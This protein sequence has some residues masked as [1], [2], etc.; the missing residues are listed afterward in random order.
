[1]A[2]KSHPDYARQRLFIEVN[3]PLLQLTLA[4][5]NA[6]LHTIIVVAAI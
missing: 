1:L 6:V 2:R 5:K 4:V 3:Q